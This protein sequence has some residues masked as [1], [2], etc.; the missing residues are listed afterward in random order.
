MRLKDF[1][2]GTSNTILLGTVAARPK[3]WGQPANVRDPALGMNRDPE[4]FG[5]PE[6]WGG[7]L[8]LMADGTVKDVSRETDPRVLHDLGTP[9]GGEGMTAMPP[10]P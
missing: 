1:A 4:G 3:P 6:H 2:D 10:A 9:A 5:G 8:L 7:G